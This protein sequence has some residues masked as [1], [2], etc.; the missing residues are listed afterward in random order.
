MVRRCMYARVPGGR[1]IWAELDR[2]L[3]FARTE[4]VSPPN[5]LQRTATDASQY[6]KHNRDARTHAKRA[7]HATAAMPDVMGCRKACSD[8]L[9]EVLR[10]GVD[11]LDGPLWHDPLLEAAY[12]RVRRCSGGPTMPTRPV[13]RAVR[14]TPCRTVSPGAAVFEYRKGFHLLATHCADAVRAHL[15]TD[16]CQ[17]GHQGR[18][19]Q[20]AVGL[21]ACGT[22]PYLITSELSLLTTIR[23]I[24]MYM[25]VWQAPIR[26]DTNVHRVPRAVLAPNVP[27]DSYALVRCGGARSTG[28]PRRT[29]PSRGDERTCRA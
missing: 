7:M 17:L 21:W 14:S 23:S 4:F 16:R 8:L 18:L 10:L 5:Q 20:T 12:R 25:T 13:P 2:D 19:G 24:A 6:V 9:N 27:S 22:V 28:V 29:R 3:L 1:Y 11:H 15:P 26:K